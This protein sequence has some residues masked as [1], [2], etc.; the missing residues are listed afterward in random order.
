MRYA[1]LRLC[2]SHALEK[3]TTSIEQHGQLVPVVVVAESSNQ[4][5]LIDGHLRVKA[6]KRLGRDT[7]E[8]EQWRCD[9][10]KALLMVLKNHSA[11]TL[12]VLEEALLLQELH[13]QHKLSQN[14]LAARLGRDKSWI[15]R[16]L[17]VL[18]FVSNT[19]LHALLNGKISLWSVMRVLAPLARANSTHSEKLLNYL[20]THC[21]T[22]RELR[23]FQEHYEK[24][25]HKKRD[26]MLD[27]P[28]LFFKAQN[29]IEKEKNAEIL[30]LGPEG[31]WEFQLRKITT[32]LSNV[33]SMAPEVIYPKQPQEETL[34]LLHWFN[35]AKDKFTMLSENLEAL[36]NAQ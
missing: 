13:I 6:L 30:K 16:R 27:N 19:V 26:E 3:L 4:W 25:N 21:H 15:S 36:K 17:A 9:T 5:V 35:Q 1:H 29:F 31:K 22:T 18:E 10:K 28:E 11:R 14:D 2:N 34:K 8:A 24:C 12:E 23:S 33:V 7:L 32:L 20:L